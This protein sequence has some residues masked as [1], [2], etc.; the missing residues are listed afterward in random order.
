M[1]W[2]GAYCQYAG[3]VEGAPDAS[4][5]LNLCRGHIKFPFPCLANGG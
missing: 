5:A 2:K 4:V 3:T 1:D